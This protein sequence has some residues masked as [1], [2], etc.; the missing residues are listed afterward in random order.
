MANL[1]KGVSPARLARNVTASLQVTY[2]N[3]GFQYYILARQAIFCAFMPVAGILSHH[4]IEMLLYAGLAS[5]F[6][7]AELR[8]RYRKKRHSLPALWEDFKEIAG[9]G[10]EL[11]RLDG[12]I[13]HF[14]KWERIRYPGKISATH[15]MTV[16]NQ[17]AQSSSREGIWPKIEDENYFNA[18][19][20]EIDEIVQKITSALGINHGFV[21]HLISVKK[22][23][24]ELYERENNFPI[25]E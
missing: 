13:Q 14:H 4:A 17:R 8:E 9:K 25:G 16:S 5:K 10:E 24:K 18:S 21:L 7:A 3:T 6:T 15:V 2:L 22:E 20:D 1:S 11:S 19:L 12:T 23:A